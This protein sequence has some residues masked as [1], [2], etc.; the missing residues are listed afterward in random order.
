MTDQQLEF[1]R[2]LLEEE[3]GEVLSVLWDQLLQLWPEAVVVETMMFLGLGVLS[4]AYTP[5]Q[6]IER[7]GLDK[8]QIYTALGTE[9]AAAWREIIQELGYTA[10]LRAVDP[11]LKKSAATRSRVCLTIIL[12]DSLFRRYARRMA[13]IFKW[14]GGAFHAV[15][16]GHDVVGLI[17]EVEGH[18]FILDWVV[19][20]KCGRKRKPRWKYAIEML[21]EF[22]RR[23]TEAGID[24]AVFGLAMDWWYGQVKELVEAAVELGLTVVSE[25]AINEIF[26]VGGQELTAKELKARFLVRSVWGGYPTQRLRATSKTFGEVLLVLFKEGDTLTVLMAKVKK[27]QQAQR[28]LRA[29]PVIRI[30]KQRPWIEQTWRWQKS[31]LRTGKI[32]VRTGHKPKAGY[33]CRMV[34]YAILGELQRRLRRHRTIGRQSIGTL[35]DWYQRLGSAFKVLLRRLQGQF[36]HLIPD[37]MASTS[38]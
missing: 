13:S 23:L 33:T 8:N 11:V 19:A 25:P 1:H 7:L 34:T 16:K 14:W 17:I 22:E 3:L 24:P 2:E 32:Q 5:H 20:S 15:R 28:E 9:T 27:D 4:G 31:Q 37:G 12:D 6:V 35:L 21:S 29:L 38:G 30:H 36:S 26:S 18:V 10:F